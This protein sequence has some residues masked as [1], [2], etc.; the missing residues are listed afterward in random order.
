MIE[1]S[2]GVQGSDLCESPNVCGLAGIM[3]DIQDPFINLGING[4]MD[5]LGNFSFTGMQ[6][7]PIPS[8][9]DGSGTLNVTT[10]VGIFDTSAFSCTGV[11]DL[12]R[13]L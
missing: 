5:N 1:F 4:T 10:G 8:T 12:K 6:T 9:V 11:L 3:F 7:S 13:P 2:I